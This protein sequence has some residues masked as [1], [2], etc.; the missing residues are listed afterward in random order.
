LQDQ[1][2]LKYA[3]LTPE[4]AAAAAQLENKL[5][6]SQIEKGLQNQAEKED[7]INKNILPGP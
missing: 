5:I 6:A 7:L 4:L 3:G 1:N 2:V